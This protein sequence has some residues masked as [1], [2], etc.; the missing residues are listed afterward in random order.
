MVTAKWL[1]ALKE[2]LVTQVQ[3]IATRLATRVGE[4]AERYARPL[5][6]LEQKVEHYAARVAAHLKKMGVEW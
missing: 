6:K 3:G 2:A 5:P 4:L 1:A